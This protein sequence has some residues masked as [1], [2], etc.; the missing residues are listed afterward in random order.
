LDSAEQNFIEL[1]QKY[2]QPIFNYLYRLS[3]DKGAAEEILQDSFLKVY[4]NLGSFRGEASVKTWLYKIARNTFLTRIRKEG[5]LVSEPYPKEQE[6]QSCSRE[7]HP[8]DV[9]LNNELRS[10]LLIILSCLPENY[11]TMIVLRDV[12]GLSYRE[13]AQ[14]L[15]LSLEQVKVTIYRARRRFRELYQKQRGGGK[16]EGL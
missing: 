13:I 6:I 3:G 1:Y 10:D 8:E 15:D 5:R 4:L 16:I 2:K 9:A 12:N 7:D 14:V 11:R